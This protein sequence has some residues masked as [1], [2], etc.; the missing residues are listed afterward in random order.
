MTKF[1]DKEDDFRDNPV[2]MVDG[3]WETP[4][5][6]A[7]QITESQRKAIQD[8]RDAMNAKQPG[9]PP[10]PEYDLNTL[11]Q[12]DVNEEE[13]YT[14]VL[15]DARHR[16][17]LG[18]LWE[19]I[20]NHDLF[21]NT[22]ADPIAARHVQN[23]IRRFAKE[24]IE[25]MLGM[26]KETST[27]ERLE[28]D[29]P[30]NQ[31]EVN[32]LKKLAHAASKGQSENSDRYVPAV[33]R[34]TEEIPTLPSAPPK[35]EGLNK[36]SS[37]SQLTKPVPAPVRQQPQA[38]KAPVKQQE[39]VKPLP[40]KAVSPI[41]RQAAAE[42]GLNSEEAKLLEMDYKPLSKHPSEMTEQELLDRARESAQRRAKHKSVK[43]KSAL[44]MPSYQEEEMLAAQRATDQSGTVNS[45]VALI[46]AQG[47][48]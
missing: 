47:K 44:P 7:P 22:D 48:K 1:W 17:E 27:V 41:V 10:E 16:L 9:P 13:D 28:I 11:P 15:S 38:P 2:E 36:I 19:M 18:R 46:S 8:R 21:D 29:F 23:E 3:N 5:Q 35:R 26:R 24:R 42:Q 40:T 32:V 37:R 33:T 39:P 31:V 14:A 12:V 6:D 43:S 30:F 20:I 25:V 4:T 34:T 45:I